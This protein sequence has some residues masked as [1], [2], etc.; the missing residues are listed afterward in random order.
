MAQKY[1]EFSTYKH[2]GK[3]F[4]NFPLQQQGLKNILK[5]NLIM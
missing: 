1:Q 2:A 3:A 4:A 5:G